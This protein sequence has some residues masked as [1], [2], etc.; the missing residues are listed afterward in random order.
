MGRRRIKA[1]DATEKE[2]LDRVALI[3]ELTGSNAVTTHLDLRKCELCG[4]IEELR[5]YGSMGENVCFD[6]GK[7]DENAMERGAN[8]RLGLGGPL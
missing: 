1:K 4:D 5:P 6:C 7:K 2:R 8:L 3:K